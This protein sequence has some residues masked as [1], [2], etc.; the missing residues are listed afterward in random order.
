MECQENF[1]GWSFSRPE[2][3]DNN[4]CSQEDIQVYFYTLYIKQCKLKWCTRFPFEAI[5][6]AMEKL[7][8]E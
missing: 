2:I 3:I 8:W 1:S 5:I 6:Y 4:M 7:L